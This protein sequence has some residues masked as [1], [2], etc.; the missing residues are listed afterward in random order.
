MIR[1]NDIIQ[2]YTVL[3]VANGMVLAHSETAPDPYVVWHITEDGS[4]VYG[5]KYLPNKEDAEWDFCMKAF[6]WFEDNA[7]INII[8]D[9]AAERID[10]FNWHLN[11]AK[12]RVESCRSVL[13]EI[14][15]AIDN[16]AALVED[17]VAEHEKLVSKKEAPQEEN[18]KP[19]IDQPAVSE[20]LSK[21]KEG[22]K[23]SGVPDT[24][25]IDN[26]ST[27]D[28]PKGSETVTAS[29]KEFSNPSWTVAPRLA[30]DEHGISL[31][32]VYLPDITRFSLKDSG[33]LDGT[34]ILDIETDVRLA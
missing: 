26:G 2:G 27:F 8:E 1:N 9:R 17:M 30:I 16:A 21:L 25:V 4:D 33:D 11:D 5:G 3:M 13:D 12:E 34:F 19:V 31:G 28:A 32:G 7:P 22:I 24:V 10:T 18:A 29:K 20:Q 14:Q 15:Q 6:P 23:Q